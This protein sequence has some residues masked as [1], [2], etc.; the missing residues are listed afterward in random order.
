MT[1]WSLLNG[2]IGLGA[3]IGIAFLVSNNKRL[4]DWRLVIS[5]FVLQV[6]FAV[7]MLKGDELAPYFSP[8]GWPKI[9][10]QWISEGFVTVLGFTTEGAKFVFGNLAIDTGNEGSM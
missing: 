6:I 1:T 5:G 9:L 3:L 2:F 4:I 7:F 10:F 8:L